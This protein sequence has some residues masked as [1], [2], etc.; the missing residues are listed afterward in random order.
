[1]PTES[2]VARGIK[3]A[4]VKSVKILGSNEEL[5]FTRRTAIN[6]ISIKDPDGEIIID[7]RGKN[8]SGLIPVIVL[9]LSANPAEVA[10]RNW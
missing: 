6:D 10:L 4:R 8:L 1:M 7:V 5:K 2:V 3:V 9:D